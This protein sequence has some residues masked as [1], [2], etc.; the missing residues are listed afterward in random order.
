MKA[1]INPENLPCDAQFSYVSHA[2][3]LGATP[4]NC[5]RLTDRWL[6]DF[7][8]LLLCSLLSWF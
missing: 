2:L 5:F 6:I 4:T 7:L 8:L 1:K 3:F